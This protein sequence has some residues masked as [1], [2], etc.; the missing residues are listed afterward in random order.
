MSLKFKPCKG[1]FVIMPSGALGKVGKK[2]TEPRQVVTKS[3]DLNESSSGF[4]LVW[5]LQ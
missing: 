2:I 1:L 3:A 5:N 4:T